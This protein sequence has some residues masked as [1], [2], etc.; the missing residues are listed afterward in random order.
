[1]AT[2]STNF[3]RHARVQAAA[4]RR[5]QREEFKN[6]FRIIT[7]DASDTKWTAMRQGTRITSDTLVRANVELK[8]SYHRDR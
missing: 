4:G 5:Q 8:A 7:M 1:M 6:D 3:R 2:I